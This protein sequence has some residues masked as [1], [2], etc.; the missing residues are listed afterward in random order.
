MA[1]TDG[2]SRV[3]QLSL[4]LNWGAMVLLLTAGT[5]LTR[6][7]GHPITGTLL[8]LGLV[9]LPVAWLAALVACWRERGRLR[10]GALLLVAYPLIDAVIWAIALGNTQAHRYDPV[11][12]VL[13]LVTALGLGFATLLVVLPLEL[14][15]D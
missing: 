1:K 5:L 4:W 3:I 9:A 7:G 12:T 10:I 11:W 14:G 15:V 13:C 8:V 6:F 2:R